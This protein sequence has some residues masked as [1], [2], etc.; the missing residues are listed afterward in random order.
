MEKK[1]HITS[2]NGIPLLHVNI[3]SNTKPDEAINKTSNKIR[4]IDVGQ[5]TILSIF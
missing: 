1:K 5:N 2:G 3:L 4:L